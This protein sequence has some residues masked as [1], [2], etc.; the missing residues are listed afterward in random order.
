MPI[1]MSHLQYQA[2]VIDPSL[3]KKELS[4]AKSGKIESRFNKLTCCRTIQKICQC[5]FS[6]Q[7]GRQGKLKPCSW[8]MSATI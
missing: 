8:W 6:D 3:Q 1:L 5:P 2:L 7:P 4:Y